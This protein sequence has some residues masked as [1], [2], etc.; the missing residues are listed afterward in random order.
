MRSFV[1]W[2]L[3]AA[4]MRAGIFGALVALLAVC[5]MAPAAANAAAID[6]VGTDFWLGFP[7]NYDNFPTLTIFISGEEATS[8]TVAIP[9]LGFSSNFT[10]TPGA[11][12][13]VVV[14]AGAQM[15]GRGT[16]VQNNGIHVTALKDVSV[17]GL[18]QEPFTTDAYLGLPVDALGTSYTVLAWGPGI[19]G[20][21]EFSVVATQDETTVTIT[22]S[23]DA[24]GHLA[25]IPFNI[26]LDKGRQY[27]LGAASGNL[28]LTGTRVAADKPVA[29]FAGHQCANIPSTGYSACDHVVEQMP[30][31]SAWGTSFL[32]VPL[33]TRSGGDTFEVVAIQAGTEVRV[34]GTLVATLGAG[35]RYSQIISGQGQIESTKPILVAQYA[36]S[37]SFDNAVSDP[38]E[39][40]VPP[41]EQYQKSY[42]V[43]TPASGFSGNFVNII[44]PAASVG[45]IKVD[46]TIVPAAS[47]TPIGTTGFSGAQV[48]IAAGSHTVTGNGQP[49]GVFTYGFGN[50]DSYGY[51]G[52]LSLAPVAT[53]SSVAL[54]PDTATNPHN[55]QDC[56]KATITDSANARVPGVRVDFTVTGVNPMTGSSNAD[57]NG[58]ATY[59]YTGTNSGSDSI[60]AAV[61]QLNSSAVSKTW[62]DSA[63]VA[64]DDEFTID[65]DAGASS[66][67]VLGN[68]TDADN[69]AIH[70]TGIGGAH[71]HGTATFTDGGISYTPDANYCGTDSLTYSVTGGD[72]ATVALTITCVDDPAVANDDEATV[73]EDSA[74]NAFQVL[75]NDSDAD[76]D[77]IE[78][79]DVGD[80]DHG[81]TA[82]VDDTVTYTPDANFCG[83]DSFTYTVDGGDTATVSVTVTCVDDPAVANDDEA[84]VD[85]DSTDN[86]FQVLGNDT[87]ADGDPIEITD[88]GDPDHGTTAIVD[89]TVTYTPDA[90]YLRR[91]HLHVHRDRR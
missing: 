28:D 75:G 66:L 74:D 88:V 53:V 19:S 22:P 91:R 35:Q 16:S 51:A 34:N 85:E 49:F 80:P 25:G 70:V 52:G 40:I 56:V 9:G 77:A 6:N 54:S 64:N 45:A 21:S 46:G 72:T 83:D 68:D 14:P 37:S 11:V 55:T 20:G 24:Q 36:N 15:P 47:F 50:Y 26:T 33:K 27:Q 89:D 63:A 61:G 8:G 86:A 67:A 57:S 41:K 76:G 90:N 58:E 81:T 13:S 82:I 78:I 2:A 38:F 60:K 87:D 1:G 23:V 59:C 84:T 42:T 18:N 62:T 29:V 4:R 71:E 17:Y 30:P 48:T 79:T 73:D 7:S 65:E 31:E 39:M 3:P 5:A 10:V 69:D 12:T 44:A 32:T 43:T